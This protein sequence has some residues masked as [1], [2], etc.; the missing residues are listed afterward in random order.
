MRDP[1]DVKLSNSSDLQSDSASLCHK[2]YKHIGGITCLIVLIVDWVVYA[3]IMQSFKNGYNHLFFIRYACASGYM[4]GVIP[5][6]FLYKRQLKKIKSELELQG[7]LIPK[8]SLTKSDSASEIQVPSAS[9]VEEI[10]LCTQRESNTDMNP[11]ND[12]HNGHLIINHPNHNHENHDDNNNQHISPEDNPEIVPPFQFLQQMIP[13][14]IF[15]GLC[16]FFCGY[17]W[18]LSLDHTFVAANNTIYQSQC[19]FVLLLSPF[20]LNTK[21]TSDQMLRARIYINV[22]C[23][24][25]LL[26]NIYIHTDYI[27]AIICSVISSGWSR[28]GFIWN[29]NRK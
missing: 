20:F 24:F 2:I 17:V 22:Y 27:Y 6:Y 10:S 9:I 19:V 1:D 25:F 14:I 12:N 5:W 8:Q 4:L 26:H 16:G 18:Y 23:I 15:V 7:N 28:Y 3:E 29:Y 11:L 13:G 21:V